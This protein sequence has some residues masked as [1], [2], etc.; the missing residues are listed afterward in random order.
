MSAR[1]MSAR[2]PMVSARSPGCRTPKDTAVSH[3]VARK[4]M[5]FLPHDTDAAAEDRS[6]RAKLI[7]AV[8]VVCCWIGFGWAVL[9]WAF[10]WHS[11]TALYVITQIV[12]TIGYGDHHPDTQVGRLFFSLYCVLTL[13]LLGV[14]LIELIATV[15]QDNISRLQSAVTSSDG[16]T[17]EQDQDR[18][19]HRL[20]VGFGMFVFFLIIGTIIFGTVEACSCSYGVDHIKGCLEGSQCTETGGVTKTW[21]DCFYLSVL[22]LTTIGFGDLTPISKLGRWFMIPWSLIGTICMA[23]FVN[24]FGDHVR[25]L[26]YVPK[27]PFDIS[28][29]HLESDVVLNREDFLQFVLIALDKVKVEDLKA[30]GKM[31]DEIDNDGNGELTCSEV[32]KFL[33]N[34]GYI[35]DS[36]RKDKVSDVAK[37]DP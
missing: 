25:S 23:N 13:C 6:F 11:V 29:D 37:L 31:Y 35:E 17:E 20:L 22:T 26:L 32:Q 1:S 2:S 19:D 9:V 14:L 36:P 8:L 28:A 18:P 30:I 21:I 3:A 24:V 33:A 27:R 10:E 15:V 34:G 16:E 4:L 12:T 7:G 5:S